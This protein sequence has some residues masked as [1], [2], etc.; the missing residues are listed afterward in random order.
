MAIPAWS[1]HRASPSRLQHATLVLLF[2]L[3]TG[4][5]V[6]FFQQATPM[7]TSND[8]QAIDCLDRTLSRSVVIDGAYGDAT[9][10]I[11]A[12]TGRMVT[13][14]HIHISLDSEYVGQ[15]DRLTTEH[16]FVGE[17][18]VYGE[19]VPEVPVAEV[20]CHR[21]SAQ[22]VRLAEP[23]SIPRAPAGLPPD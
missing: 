21:G 1:L 22:A 15:Q 9:Q 12:L 2:T 23:I 18:R 16:R 8:L 6:V 10:W 4:A 20:V 17:R 13:R 5:N 11:P 7:A 14:P 19:A 3:A